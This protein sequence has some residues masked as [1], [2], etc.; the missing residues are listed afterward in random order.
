MYSGQDGVYIGL[1]HQ[2]PEV[3]ERVRL[4]F[5]EAGIEIGKQYIKN[6]DLVDDVVNKREDFSHVIIN[7]FPVE[8]MKGQVACRELLKE[9][10]RLNMT[11]LLGRRKM[12]SD[13][14]G[15]YAR[16]S[17]S[18]GMSDFTGISEEDLRD[19]ITKKKY[20]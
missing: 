8:G 20:A 10:Y 13:P 4:V 11:I 12:G 3:R 14:I 2:N 9:G 1:S 19:H 16:R 18:L 7:D 15:R 17:V 5:A 6:E